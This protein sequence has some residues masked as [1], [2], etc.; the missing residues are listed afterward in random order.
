MSHELHEEV[1]D[2]VE[3]G[4]NLKGKKLDA[5]IDKLYGEHGFGVQVDIMDL[6]KIHKAGKDAYVSGGEDAASKAVAAA[7][8]KYRKN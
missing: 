3:M 6:G 7:L 2:L 4:P 1:D 8:K 5:L